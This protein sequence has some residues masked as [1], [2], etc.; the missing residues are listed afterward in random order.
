MFGGEILCLEGLTADPL[1]RV[2]ALLAA[3]N[4]L[5]AEMVSVLGVMDAEKLTTAVLG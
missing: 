4:Q 1:E 2:S 3:R 5:E